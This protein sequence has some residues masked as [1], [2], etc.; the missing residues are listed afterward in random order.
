MS[1][2]LAKRSPLV[3]VTPSGHGTLELVMVGNCVMSRCKS[4]Y[5]ETLPFFADK[6]MTFAI[7]LESLEAAAAYIS[8][9]DYSSEKICESNKRKTL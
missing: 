3:L 6:L 1:G 7:V 9:K 5:C 8:K 2:K 4:P